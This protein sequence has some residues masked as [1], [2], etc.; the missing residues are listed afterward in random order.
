MGVLAFGGDNSEMDNRLGMEVRGTTDRHPD[1]VPDPTRSSPSEFHPRSAVVA[2]VDAIEVPE[3]RGPEE[4][5][6]HLRR[7]AKPGLELRDGLRR[8]EV[9]LASHAET[10]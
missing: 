2:G 5:V 7:A 4:V 6:V 10:P 1:L 3:H 8:R 9:N